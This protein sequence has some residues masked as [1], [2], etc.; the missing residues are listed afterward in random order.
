M[1]TKLTT[2]DRLDQLDVQVRE[3]RRAISELMNVAHGVSGSGAIR[4]SPTA[5]RIAAEIADETEQ[6]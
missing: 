4:R 5:A 1:T 2:V 6:I 3:L